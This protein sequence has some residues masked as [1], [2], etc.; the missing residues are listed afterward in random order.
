MK[1]HHRRRIRYI[2]RALQ[3]WLIALLVIIE[4]VL[5]AGS[6]WLLYTRWNALVEASVFRV[7]FGDAPSLFKSMQQELE[8]VMLGWM[9]INLALLLLIEAFWSLRVRRIVGA[10]R[11][12]LRRST[13]LDFAA[14]AKGPH[15]HPVL[16]AALAWREQERLRHV[17]IRAELQH[18]KSLAA[19]DD[20]REALGRIAAHLN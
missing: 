11:E 1:T 10:L 16:A 9:G 18:L 13:S 4:I 17:A 14:D 8:H 19:A 15:Q 12:L 6:I 7:H 5:V 20:P 2:D 3:Q